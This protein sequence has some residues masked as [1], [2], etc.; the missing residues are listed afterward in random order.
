MRN[1]RVL[2]MVEIAI[3]GALGYVL[4][5]VAFKMPQGGSV[6]LVMIPIVLMAFRRGTAA[7]IL[8]GLLV[9]LLQIVTGVISVTPLSFGF[10]VMQ[11]ILDYLVAYGVVGFAG[12]LRGN[13]LKAL[14]Q[15]KSGGMIAAVVIG[16]LI[17]SLLRYLMHVI[18]GVLFF[19]MFAEGNVLIY[20]AVYNATYMIP[21][22]LL[23]AAVCSALFTA[24]PKL[25]DAE[26]Q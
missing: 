10:V 17:A 9:G 3:F 13:Y 12:L 4:D 23:A 7:G 11:V 20:S 2:L 18:T 22:F 21:V 1:L 26:V 5:F 25:V 14:Q 6:S 15:G 19:G 8:T 16:V 24:A